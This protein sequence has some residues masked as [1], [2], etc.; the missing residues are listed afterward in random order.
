MLPTGSKPASEMW[1]WVIISDKPQEVAE[2]AGIN[3]FKDSIPA[4]GNCNV[5]IDDGCH[6]YAQ[7]V[8]YIR[9]HSDSGR[10]AF[11]IFADRHSVIISP[12]MS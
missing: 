3:I 9:E 1:P 11:H 2:R 12:K 10:L 7:V 8:D 5:L 6:S 4:T